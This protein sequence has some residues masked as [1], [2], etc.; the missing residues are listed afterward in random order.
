MLQVVFKERASVHSAYCHSDI[1]ASV[2]AV[3][4]QLQGVET[5]TAQALVHQIAP[6]LESMIRHLT[7]AREPLLPGYQTKF[8]DGNYLEATEF[9]LKV[10]LDTPAGALPGK[11]LVVFDAALGLALDVLPC[12]DGQAQERALLTAVAATIQLGYLWVAD[13]NF[14]VLSFLFDLARKDAFFVIRQHQNTPYTPLPDLKLMGRSATGQVF[15]Q[16]VQLASPDGEIF[17]RAS[18]GDSLTQADPKRR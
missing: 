4:G 5:T 7:G 16:L 8:L 15:E 18:G 9:R 1:E 2:V 12:E 3:Y 6:N 17:D 10:L 13:R 14:S 11:T